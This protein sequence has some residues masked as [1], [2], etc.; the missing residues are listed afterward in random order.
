MKKKKTHTE[1]YLK[2]NLIGLILLHH[3]WNNGQYSVLLSIMSGM[4]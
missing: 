1:I 4:T 2:M 3:K